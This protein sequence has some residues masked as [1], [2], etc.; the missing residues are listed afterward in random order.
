MFPWP[1]NKPSV[2]EQRYSCCD[3]ALKSPADQ[4]QQKK[5]V[6]TCCS[7]VALLSQAQVFKLEA[8]KR[9]K[10]LRPLQGLC[11]EEKH[12][13][14]LIAS[15]GCLLCPPLCMFVL[16]LVADSAPLFN[17]TTYSSCIQ[18][19]WKRHFLSCGCSIMF[20][21]FFT[22]VHGKTLWILPLKHR[23]SSQ[24]WFNPLPLCLFTSRP[25]DRRWSSQTLWK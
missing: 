4:I 16:R 8:R 15:A 2:L 6:W 22:S 3:F 7:S 25:V 13:T 10:S 9:K 5:P 21:F 11:D 14:D 20:F 19:G 18:A 1:H 23:I 24:T 17:Y 12:L